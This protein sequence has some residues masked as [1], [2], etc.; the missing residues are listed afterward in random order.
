[1]VQRDEAVTRGEIDAGLAFVRHAR[2]ANMELRVACCELRVST[3]NPQLATSDPPPPPR[4]RNHRDHRADEHDQ[5]DAAEEVRVDDEGNPAAE[6]V[7]LGHAPRV[8]E[9]D[10]AD[11]AEEEA[12][13]EGHQ[14]PGA[15]YDAQ[16]AWCHFTQCS[17]RL[18]Q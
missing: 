4:D 17:N 16:L 1:T 13:E 15:P 7:D 8:G 11:R 18:W 2:N 10:A 14:L 5:Q 3:R 9:V 12:D 6:E